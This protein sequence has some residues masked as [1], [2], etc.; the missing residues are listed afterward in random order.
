MRMGHGRCV[1]SQERTGTDPCRSLPVDTAGRDCDQMIE[2]TTRFR[3]LLDRL[4]PNPY[5]GIPVIALYADTVRTGYRVPQTHRVWAFQ[6][7]SMR[8]RPVPF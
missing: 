7:K 5:G 1:S 4:I 6:E 8:P 2:E 3:T